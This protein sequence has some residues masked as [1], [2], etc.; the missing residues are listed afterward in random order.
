MQTDFEREET[1]PSAEK[2]RVV[3]LVDFDG[4]ACPYKLQE[5]NIEASLL[6]AERVLQTGSMED[7]LLF[8]KFLDEYIA[9]QRSDIHIYSASNR[10]SEAIDEEMS[11]QKGFPKTSLGALRELAEKGNTRRKCMTVHDNRLEDVL[12]SNT[13]IDDTKLLTALNGMWSSYEQDPDIW[14]E[15]VFCD[16][17]NDICDVVHEFFAKNPSFI[18]PNM[19][20]T[21]KAI[22][23]AQEEE[24]IDP[25][26]PKRCPETKAPIIG[27]GPKLKTDYVKSMLAQCI[28]EGYKKMPT[29]MVLGAEDTQEYCTELIDILKSKIVAGPIAVSPIRKTSLKAAGMKVRVALFLAN[30]QKESN[31]T[32]EKTHEGGGPSLP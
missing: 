19:T 5:D 3:L 24:N 15:C 23:D 10:Q 30:S 8:L 12:G 21:I 18:P 17:R 7:D 11:R 31:Q 6:E 16:D 27:R 22:Q 2:K 32:R 13:P 14:S 29:R 20:L 4:C 1:L 9:D 25:E 26:S 28:D